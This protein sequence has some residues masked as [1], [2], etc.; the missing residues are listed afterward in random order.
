MPATCSALT[1][2]RGVL[3]YRQAA[4]ALP[5]RCGQ[6]RAFVKGGGVGVPLASDA[7]PSLLLRLHFY[8]TRPSHR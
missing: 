6:R 2:E 7:R 4:C 5:F 3:V 8:R 1:V